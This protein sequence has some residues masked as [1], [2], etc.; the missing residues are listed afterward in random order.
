MK[1]RFGFGTADLEWLHPE[2]FRSEPIYCEAPQNPDD[3]I[4]HGSD[5]EAYDNPAER[6]LRYE[7][8]AQR[9]L[10]GK[11]VFLLSASLRGPFE[12]KSG[13][14][15]PWRSK[16]DTRG[17]DRQK[18]IQC[19]PRTA[20]ETVESSAVV[21]SSSFRRETSETRPTPL[22]H[23]HTPLRY[24][25]DDTFHRV[26]CWRDKVIVESDFPTSSM[27]D[28]SQ[29]ESTSAISRKATKHTNRRRSGITL[30]T[31]DDEASDLTSN[32][33]RVLNNGQQNTSPATSRR[34]GTRGMACLPSKTGLDFTS[35]RLA[36]SQN[37]PSSGL[38]PPPTSL[39]DPTDL[40]PRAVLEHRR[41]SGGS[42]RRNRLS[43]AAPVATDKTLPA[44]IPSKAPLITKTPATNSLMET[45]NP[46]PNIA[47][48]ETAA[49]SAP[50][51]AQVTPRTDGSF[52][53]QRMDVQGNKS[54]LH[55]SRLANAPLAP[56]SATEDEDSGGQKLLE[57]PTEDVRASHL[58]SPR[59]FP[60]SATITKRA[61]NVEDHG[62]AVEATEH[63][64]T[65]DEFHTDA[66]IVIA[67]GSPEQ[68]DNQIQNQIEEEYL[69]ETP[70]QID[71]PTLVQSES[72]SSSQHASLPSFGHFSAE[73]QSQDVISEVIGFPRRLLWPKSRRSTQGDSLPIF[74]VEPTY[75]QES[76]D[77][78]HVFEYAR[79]VSVNCSG[80][81]NEPVDTPGEDEAA[82]QPAE[83]DAE[84]FI[85]VESLDVGEVC[86]EEAEPAVGTANPD[87]GREVENYALNDVEQVQ[88]EAHASS[89]HG[90][91][92]PNNLQRASSCPAPHNQSPWVNDGSALRFRSQSLRPQHEGGSEDADSRV[93]PP[94]TAQSP[95]TTTA[96][97]V[98]GAPGIQ[99]SFPC[100]ES[101]SAKLSFIASQALQQAVSQSPW[102]R[103]DS[104][105]QLPEVRLF[106]PLSSPAN[107]HVLPAIDPLHRSDVPCNDD[108]DMC[109]SQLHPPQPSTPET[110]QSG[111]PSPDF[112]LSVKSFKNFMTPS[113]AKRRRV[114]TIING[115]HL[116]NSQSVVDAAI[117]NPWAKPSTAKS[118]ILRS[119]T[120][121][122]QHQEARSPKRVSWA[123][124]PG[125]STPDSANATSTSRCDAELPV[126]TQT[127][128]SPTSPSLR[129]RRKM[130]SGLARRPF[131][132]ASPP[133]PSTL[134]ASALPTASQK[135]AR[136]FAAVVAAGGISSGR[137]AGVVGGALATPRTL[138]HTTTTTAA[139]VRRFLPS[140]SQQVCGSP[141]VEAMAEAFLRAEAL[142]GSGDVA[143]RGEEGE[144]VRMEP[145]TMEGVLDGE[146]T[147][148]GEEEV[149]EEGDSSAAKGD[150]GEEGAPGVA[151]EEAPVDEVSAVMEN[152]DDF[153]GVNWDLDADLAK[154]RTEHTRESREY[155]A[156]DSSGGANLSGLLAV[157]VWD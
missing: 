58:Q 76:A 119:K 123:P 30:D 53:Y 132:A 128:S 86:M 112:T 84:R 79:S 117:S 140:S 50:P 72:P 101:A 47:L 90:H 130:K 19:A 73:K 1:R 7:A 39:S 153:L 25:D 48:L 94:R 142:G 78:G 67:H 51:P 85:N 61:G 4:Y 150:W 100:S 3:I 141:A 120:V 103:G 63:R 147:G 14:V 15:N 133:P 87:T 42:A 144:G 68:E 13:W 139:G 26:R 33:P 22:Q 66:S 20:A 107:S 62:A 125:E 59:M 34:K 5:D 134:S 88:I 69:V 151:D 31:F 60:A 70:S 127:P 27:Q 138:Q 56:G 92:S 114:S 75:T 115:E 121:R 143:E 2:N 122:S 44:S 36:A 137:G 135:F 64:T 24:M 18:K 49:P 52:R 28:S 116:P 21:D 108:A 77:S 99:I 80:L 8:Q 149:E 74:G 111:L 65:K 109:N 23:T 126:R 32:A 154:A 71:G 96:D 146:Y 102:T 89:S 11:P 97:V 12:K 113:P 93:T 157:N 95:W 91:P 110:K 16:S 29:A 152:L 45:G 136:H 156:V 83:K 46:T 10:E 54:S 82:Y 145:E 57:R 17:K 6:R 155:D 9:F 37:R 118:K 124:L 129:K 104:Q 40:P 38:S 35:S 148:G 43:A 55:E 98:P 105:M 81:P 106:N 41:S 131:R